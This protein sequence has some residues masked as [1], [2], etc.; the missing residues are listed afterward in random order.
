M[1]REPATNE[2]PTGARGNALNAISARYRLAAGHLFGPTSTPLAAA[3]LLLAWALGTRR[4]L[5]DGSFWESEAFIAHNLLKL[6]PAALFGPLLTDHS[7]PRLYL[8]VISQ[9]MHLFGYETLVLR[10]LPWFFFMVA[11]ALLV[12]LLGLRFRDRPGLLAVALML[13]LA[14]PV[15]FAYAAMLKQYTLELALTLA[16]IA[17]PDDRLDQILREGR[18]RARLWLFA[19]PCLLSY[20][21]AIVLIAR[22]VGWWGHGALQRRFFVDG[23]S[24][25]LLALTMAAVVGGLWWIELRHTAGTDA[26]FRFWTKCIVGAGP[27]SAGDLLGQLLTGWWT[28]PSGWGDSQALLGGPGQLI[29]L[30]LLGLGVVNAV[31]RGLREGSDAANATERRWG[32]RSLAFAAIPVGLF[33]ASLLFGYPICANNLTLF[34]L[35]PIVCLIVEGMAM[36]LRG[37]EAK[38]GHRVGQAFQAVAVLTLIPILVSN[39][40]FQW[41]T[42]PPGDLRPLLPAIEQRPN[43]PLAVAACSRVQVETLPEWQGR[44]DLHYFNEGILDFRTGQLPSAPRFLMISASSVFLCPWFLQQMTTRGGKVRTLSSFPRSGALWL[45]DYPLDAPREWPLPKPDRPAAP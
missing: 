16:L 35:L 10:A 20:G 2:P 12:W 29:L 33:L 41:T 31:L 3:A 13:A 14:A 21:Y 40:V 42:P 19:L 24:A 25:T 28:H 44:D 9:G 45:V 8:W 18:G 15:H 37:I 4:Y 43:L 34:A 1:P 32:S 36:V 6:E 26:V 23:R 17:V 7:F 22:V 39:V 30:A 27:A 5:M 38:A 11:M